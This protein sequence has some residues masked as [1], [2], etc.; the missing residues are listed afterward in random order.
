MLNKQNIIKILLPV[1]FCL[2]V[3]LSY[4]QKTEIDL[5]AY[6]GLFSFRGNGSTSNSWVIVSNLARLDQMTS[7][8]YGK[9]G[10]FFYSY[11]LQGQRV[12]RKK[13]IYGIGISFEA[14]TS[15]I[16]I[17][18]AYS[19]GFG[20][21]LPGGGIFGP[22]P[23]GFGI[24]APH[25]IGAAGETTLKNIFITANL[26]VGHRFIYRKISLD[27]LAGIDLGFC[28]KSYE[29]ANAKSLNSNQ[30]N[31]TWWFNNFYENRTKPSIDFRPR[32]QFKIRYHIFGI[33]LGYSLGITNYQKQNNETSFFKDVSQKNGN[34]NSSILR[35][36]I[37]LQLK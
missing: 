37:S 3:Q 36:G 11:E 28:L 9:K 33:L 35:L 34:A 5:N 15:K 25:P 21:S 4:G 19:E 22:G 16:N 26:Y 32:I 17:D 24:Y 20:S 12:T 23:D 30:S 31:S 8:P 6:C 13:N 7:S 14:S 18:S 2:L 29:K 27:L 1:V 10:S